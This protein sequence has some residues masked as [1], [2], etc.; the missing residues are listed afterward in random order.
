M[1]SVVKCTHY[2]HSIVQKLFSFIFR[3][4]FL[5][6]VFTGHFN[7]KFK[8]KMSTYIFIHECQKLH[9]KL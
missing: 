2:A 3:L 1:F 4:G 8:F 7:P 5:L 9:E 6:R